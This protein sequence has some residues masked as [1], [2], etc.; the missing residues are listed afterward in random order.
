MAPP[1]AKQVL[2]DAGLS[3]QQI[4]RVMAIKDETDRKMLD[5]RHEVQKARLDL[6]GLMRADTPDEAAIYNQVDQIG[7]L[8]V[9]LHKNRIGMMLSVRKEVTPEQWE[10]LSALFARHRMKRGERMRGK[11][12]RRMQRGQMGP[13][14][15]AP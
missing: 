9:K 14:F 4:R 15:G 12:G 3:D 8:E 13:G 6:R 11:R 2:K 10:K 1:L 7:A 5:I